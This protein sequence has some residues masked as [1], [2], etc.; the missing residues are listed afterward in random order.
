MSL[1]RRG[2]TRKEDGARWEKAVQKK[3]LLTWTYV[4]HKKIGKCQSVTRS[5]H[6]LFVKKNPDSRPQYS[7]IFLKL[8]CPR[9]RD[10]FH[11][12]THARARSSHRSGRLARS[13]HA[14]TY[15]R[16]SFPYLADAFCLPTHFPRK[17]ACTAAPHESYIGQTQAT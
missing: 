8:K 5:K 3:S 6:L 11:Q 4:N 16:F 13:P 17:S 2:R 1:C 12:W 9:P 15:R 14:A 7:S 10:Y